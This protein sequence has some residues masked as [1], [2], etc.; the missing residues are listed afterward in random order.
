MKIPEFSAELSL[1]PN[2]CI[3]RGRISP[4]GPRLQNSG[5]VTPQLD[6]SVWKPYKGTDLLTWTYDSGGADCAKRC[7]EESKK[8]QESC[9]K[10]TDLVASKECY[11]EAAARAALCQDRCDASF[12]PL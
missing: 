7:I 6:T 4:G 11:D 8:A 3:Y 10:K 1:R 2:K 12:P 5:E 9:A